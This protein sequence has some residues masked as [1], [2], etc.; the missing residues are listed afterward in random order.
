MNGLLFSLPGTPVIYYGDEIG[1]G[2]NIY[3]GDRNG[4]RTPMQWSGDR[5]AGFSRANPQRLYLPVI[6]DPEYHYEAVNVEAQQANPHSLLWWMKRLIA[7]RKQLPGVR[8]RHARVP[9]PGEPARC[10]RS[11][12][13]LRGR[14]ASSS[15]PTCRASCSTSSSTCPRSR[16]WCRSSCSAASSSRAIGER[17]TSSRSARTPSYWFTLEAPAAGA[18]T[19][20]RRGVPTLVLRSLA[21]RIWPRGDADGLLARALARIPAPAGAGSAARPARSRRPRSRDVDRRA[22]SPDARPPS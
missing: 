2:D 16:A 17:R 14:D 10:W 13:Q 21:S 6:I 15:S 8:P 22:A 7:L 1:M 11:S 20:P 3:L 12:A 4:V 19:A 9:A 18:P 5:N